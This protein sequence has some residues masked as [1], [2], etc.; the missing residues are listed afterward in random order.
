MRDGISAE[1]LAA[2]DTELFDA[3]FYREVDET[4]AVLPNRAPAPAFYHR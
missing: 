1:P 3:T 4:V 2:L